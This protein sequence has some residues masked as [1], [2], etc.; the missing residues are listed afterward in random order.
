MKNTEIHLIGFILILYFSIILQGPNIISNEQDN[1]DYS[2]IVPQLA[3]SESPV[4]EWA[5]RWGGSKSGIDIGNGVAVDSSDNVYLAGET[6]SFGAGGYDMVLVKYNSSGVQQ[7]NRTWGG[8]SHDFGEGVA[9]DTSDNVYLAGTTSSF[10]AQE[11]DMVLVKYD[12]S[13]VQQWSRTWGGT[14]DDVGNGVAVDSSDN[15]YLA[16][17]TESFGAGHYDM[18]LVKYDSSGVQQWNHTWGGSEYDDGMGVAVDSSDNIYLAGGTASFGAGGGDMVLVK[19][20]SSGVEQ[21]NRTWGGIGFEIFNGVAVDSSDNACAVGET[22]SFGAGGSD[23]VL[24]KYDSSGVQQWNH[25]WGGSEYDSGM[26]VAVDSL[27]IVYLAG[28]TSSFEAQE[29]DMVLVKY[30]GSGVQQWNTIYGRRDN[31]AGHGVAVDSLGK[32]YLAGYTNRIGAY[33]L[34]MVLLKYDI[35]EDVKEKTDLVIPFELII[36][37]SVIGGGAVIGVVVVVLLRRKR[38]S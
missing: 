14:D 20:N 27:D 8:S 15:V 9:V 33:H 21:W 4:I 25:T 12:S 10:E 23:I 13:G 34:E 19:Y 18:V 1:K 36:I 28:T 11:W 17:Y 22:E 32:V 16:G 7:W 35:V 29:W 5:R 38:K 6:L 26:G 2:N 30:N 24:V 31:D 3:T 37:A